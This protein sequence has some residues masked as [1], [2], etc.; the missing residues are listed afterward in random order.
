MVIITYNSA[1]KYFRLLKLYFSSIPIGAR[2]KKERF[3]ACDIYNEHFPKEKISKN[4]NWNEW[5]W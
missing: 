2:Q 5:K 1:D 3:W 4:G